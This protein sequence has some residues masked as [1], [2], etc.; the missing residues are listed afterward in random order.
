MSASSPAIPASTAIEGESQRGARSVA[1]NLALAACSGIAL[2]CGLGASVPLGV[3]SPIGWLAPVPLLLAIRRARTPV[4][5]YGMAVLAGLVFWAFHIRW[6]LA[7]GGMNAAN[8]T[9]AVG[10]LGT[11]FGLFGPLA[12]LSKL[13]PSGARWLVTASAWAC[14]EFARLHLGFVSIPF[15]M[16]ANGQADAPVGQLASV[17]GLFAVSFVMLG[18]AAAVAEVIDRRLHSIAAFERISRV[19]LIMP[20]L[21]AS[22]ALV[23]GAAR[24]EPAVDAPAARVAFVQAGAYQRSVDPPERRREI[25]DAYRDLTAAVA[26]EGVE[27]V[28]WPASSV[29]GSIPFDSGLVRKLGAIALDNDT[30]LLVGSSGQDKSAPSERERSATNSAFLFDSRG[31]ILEHYDK[32]QLLPFNQYLP[33]RERVNWPPWV[34][35]DGID[36]RAGDHRTLFQIAGM[37]FGVLICWENL[38]SDGF[39]STVAQGLDFVVSTTNE[40]FTRTE[41]AHHQMLA[42]TRL[43]AIET[44][45]PIVR[46]ATTGISAAIDRYGRVTNQIVDSAGKTQDAVGYAIARVPMG[47]QLSFYARRGDWLAPVCAGLLVLLPAWGVARGRRAS[48]P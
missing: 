40:I 2:E 32:I 41:A 39:R 34:A 18:V 22:A 30:P 3:A 38:F 43:R 24:I 42:M 45:I 21:F 36:V 13:A 28:V 1:I 10:V 14:A 12:W 9:L 31:E 19:E 16:L 27:L 7:L 8:Y 25:L 6:L 33:L 17:G 11:L 5:A 20:L 29:P 23:W 46:T 47:S 48:A 15:G 44:G 37:R 26:A 4:S 35:G